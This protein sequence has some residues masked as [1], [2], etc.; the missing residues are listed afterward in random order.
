MVQRTRQQKQVPADPLRNIR[1][2]LCC[3]GTS[4]S[5]PQDDDDTTVP[6]AA[7]AH[8]LNKDPMDEL[9]DFLKELPKT[10]RLNVLDL[11]GCRGLKKRH[12]KS[13]CK[14][15]SLRYLSLRNTDVSGLPYREMQELRLLETLDI[16]DTGSSPLPNTKHIFLRKLRHLLAGTTT[17]TNGGTETPSDQASVPLS[18]VRMPRRIGDM[19]SME[20]LSHVQV[21]SD[22]AELDQV[23]KLQRLRKLGVVLLH[24]NNENTA[25][26]LGQV[27]TRLAGSL[28]S[29][30][31]WVGTD[32]GSVDIPKQVPDTLLILENL[33]IKGK[34]THHFWGELKNLANVTLRDTQ[35]QEDLLNLGGL[36][37]LRCLRLRRNSCAHQQALR[38][39]AGKFEALKILA[40]E[41]GTI[42]SV[43]FADGAAPQLEKIVWTF[44]KDDKVP[45]IDGIGNLGSLKLVKIRGDL[46]PHKGSELKRAIAAQKKHQVRLFD[47]ER[48]V[49]DD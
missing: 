30:S 24:G 47:G 42:I 44:D 32:D 36:Q 23:A 4:S 12:L 43:E 19:T 27:I 46:G 41:G 31:I 25:R 1:D 49:T 5:I 11:G 20:T 2:R 29:L 39:E 26:K 15:T 10:Y 6:V 8:L 40:V 16:R 38:F 7:A 9:V 14:V 3:G 22:G 28:R 48:D 35:L 33:E 37:G 18:A 21:S 17:T 34:V 13:I 45:I